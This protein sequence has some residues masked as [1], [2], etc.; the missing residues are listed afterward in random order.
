MDG[1]CYDVSISPSGW[2]R[3]SSIPACGYFN[4][5]IIFIMLGFDIF[6]VLFLRLL[7]MLVWMP[8]GRGVPIVALSILLEP[9]DFIGCLVIENDWDARIFDF[10]PLLKLDMPPSDVCFVAGAGELFWV[11]VYD[12]SSLFAVWRFE[13]LPRL[14]LLA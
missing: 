2:S 13:K 4:Y 10:K 6:T 7:L 14:R 11:C 9:P 12:R 5:D 3:L 8:S 1:F